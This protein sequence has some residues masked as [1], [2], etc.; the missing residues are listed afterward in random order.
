VSDATAYAPSYAPAR[1]PSRAPAPAPTPA[2][3]RPTAA[4]LFQSFFLAGFECSTQRRRDGTRLDMVAASRHDALAA[5]DY[6]R[7]AALD[8][9]TVRDGVRWHLGERTPGVISVAHEAARVRAARDAGVQVIWDLWHYGSPDDVDV[10][11]A[12]F[13]GRLARWARAFADLVASETGEVPFYCPV[14]EIS[15][16][17][18]GGGDV[19]YLNPFRRGRGAHLKRQLVRAA[20]EASEAVW[21]VD[22]RARLCHVD[23]VI[24]VVPASERPVDHEMAAASREAMFESW[25]LLCG[26]QEPWLGGAPRYLDVIGA[27]FYSRNQWVHAGPHLAPGDAGYRPLADLLADVHARYER[28]LFVAETGVEF[29]G[30]AAWLRM[31]GEQVRAAMRAGVPVEGVCWYPILNHPGW[32]DDRHLQCGLWDYPDP[33]GGRAAHGPLLAELRRQ[34]ALFATE[35]AGA[36]VGA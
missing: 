31:I 34:Q 7:C 27:N 6:A 35:G 13:P 9:R 16:V 15:F 26:A 21:A 20:I 32:D 5:A 25:D 23:P 3:Q 29:D 12:T 22:P 10:L 1:T 19:A 17:A 18:W 4:P 28:P 30:R 36:A 24:H 14:N 11:D 8:L 33:A 2:H